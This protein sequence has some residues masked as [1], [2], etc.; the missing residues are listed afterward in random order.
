[1]TRSG[2]LRRLLLLLL[3]L[4]YLA[5]SGLVLGCYAETNDDHTILALL[6]G[7]SA[8][9]PVTNL[10]LYFHGYAPLW[11]QLYA[12]APMVPWYGLTLYGLLYAATVLLFAVL[13]RL[14]APWLPWGW[15]WGLIT[16]FWFL[17]WLEHSFWFNYVRVPLLLAGTGVL[18]AAQR[19]G[20]WRPLALGL[21]CFLLAWL[22]RPSAAAMAL[23]AAVPGAWWLAGR[24]AFPALAGA[25]T[26]AVAGGLLLTLTRSEVAATYRRLDVLKSNLNDYQLTAPPMHPLTA[27][28]S[29]GLALARRWMVGDSTLTDE[30]FFRRATPIRL[31]YFLSGT[32]PQK[33]QQLVP[34]LGRD[35]FPVLVLLLATGAIALRSGRPQVLFW[36][37]QLGFAGGLL[38]V[39]TFLK[40]P[41]RLVLPLLDFWALGN[42]I[43]CFQQP[44]RP[45]RRPALLLLLALLVVAMPYA[46]KTSH[47]RAVL[48]AERRHNT[49]RQHTLFSGIRQGI[50]VSDIV[51]E[52]YKSASP[53]T[54]ALVP[55]HGHLVAVAGWPT[56]DPSQP[57]LRQALTGTRDFTASLRHLARR[58][59]VAWVL[60]PEAAALLNRQLALRRRPEEAQV[61]LLPL[62]P[63]VVGAQPFSMSVKAAR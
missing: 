20:R 36:L 60:T 21:I 12:L 42:L 25:A 32:A 52:T 26:L 57:A 23:V 53:F 56:L 43:F 10:H 19:P 8:A 45:I 7:V 54:E 17:A 30:A 18:Y 41:P 37:V 31:S 16:L 44:T 9:T 55:M 13:D 27:P 3:P 62:T 2:P 59:D 1:M 22:I 35:Y 4:L 14:L 33:L 63:N 24:P 40:L 47:R 34:Q 46:Y 49:A 61:Y 50:V 48:R 6:R 28:D 38:I 39:G 11:T 5:G 29:L 51:E 58:P 15:V